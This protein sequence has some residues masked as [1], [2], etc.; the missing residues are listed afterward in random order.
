M[1]I[2]IFAVNKIMPEANDS[3]YILIAIIAQATEHPRNSLPSDGNV[4]IDLPTY[5][6][7]TAP[8]EKVAN[9]AQAAA[10]TP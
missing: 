6:L 3:E 4:R 8:T 10:I 5:Q 7:T 1:P 9:V 2:V